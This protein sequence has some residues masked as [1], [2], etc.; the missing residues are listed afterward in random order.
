MLAAL[1]EPAR[2]SVGCPGAHVRTRELALLG[3]RVLGVRVPAAD[4]ALGGDCVCCL[5]R[6]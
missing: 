6:A 1:E 2:A 5:I 4:L 3:V